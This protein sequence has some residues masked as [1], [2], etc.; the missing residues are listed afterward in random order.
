MSITTEKEYFSN[1]NL[2]YNINQ[3]AYALLPT[4]DQIY[5]IDLKTRK[6]NAPSIL[7]IEQDHKSEVIYF[8]VDRFAD[9][10]DLAQ[11]CCVIKYNVQRKIKNEL[12]KRSY[13]YPVPFFDIY[14]KLNEKKLV[15]PWVLD[16]SVTA[17]PGTVEFS[18][19]FYKIGTRIK[20]DGQ[21][22][23]IYTYSLNTL[24]VQSKVEKGIYE[25]EITVEQEQKLLAGQFEGLWSA[26][27][28]IQQSGVNAQLYW[29]VLPSSY[30]IPEIN[31]DEITAELTEIESEVENNLKELLNERE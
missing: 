12:V 3:P 20:D 6:V 9:F 30:V 2:L 15:F 24:P 27:N 17:T 10:M 28:S 19:Q 25:Y 11:T 26:V 8:E 5:R 4:A 21:A 29:T 1:L 7:S 14:K 31:D 18:I 23:L 13:I 16:A 22:E